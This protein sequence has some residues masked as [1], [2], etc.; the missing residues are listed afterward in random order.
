MLLLLW[1]QAGLVAELQASQAGHSRI[2]RQVVQLLLEHKASV[3]PTD[4]DGGT[5]LHFAAMQGHDAVAVLLIEHAADISVQNTEGMSALHFA[6]LQGHVALAAL[7]LQHGA[8]MSATDNVGR[9]SLHYAALGG[10][11]QAV[12]FLLHE[13]ADEQWKTKGGLTPENLATAKS[14]LSVAEILQAEAVR[15]AQCVS[16]AMGHHPRLGAG[17]ILQEL[18]EGVLRMILERV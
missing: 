8:D 5:P 7:L 12:G 18:D 10:S 15:R 16:F 17:F 14:H 2:S 3:S 13:G 4:N 6:V 11:E 1:T 9:T